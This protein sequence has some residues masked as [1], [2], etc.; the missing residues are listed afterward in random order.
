[1]TRVHFRNG[2]L[3]AKKRPRAKEEVLERVNATV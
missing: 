2:F 3:V 1:M